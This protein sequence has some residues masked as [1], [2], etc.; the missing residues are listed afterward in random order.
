MKSGFIQIQK[1]TPQTE[2]GPSQW[3][4]ATWLLFN[5]REGRTDD[6]EQVE[7]MGDPNLQACRKKIFLTKPPPQQFAGLSFA[8]SMNSSSHSNWRHGR[9]H[10]YFHFLSEIGSPAGLPPK[11]HL[12]NEADPD[13]TSLL[14]IILSNRNASSNPSPPFCFLKCFLLKH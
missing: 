4:S 10:G 1:I 3:A 5:R 9:V 12:L 2:C 14:K 8:S 11:R 6:L 13:L 7:K